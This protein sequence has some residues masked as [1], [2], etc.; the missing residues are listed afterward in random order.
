M[1]YIFITADACRAAIADSCRVDYV[2][3][4]LEINGK[5]ERQGHLNTLISRH[6][7]EDVKKVKTVLSC[8]KLLVRVNPIHKDSAAEIASVID[9][10]AD[11]I[12]LPMFRTEAEV[13]R[14]V[15]LI[16]GRVEVV[17]LVETAASLIRLKSI[18]EIGGVDSIHV[19]LNDLH[20]E[21]RL[22][23]MFEIVSDG[24]MDWVASMCQMRGVKF[25]FGGVG[26]IGRGAVPAEL[27]LAEHMR[28]GSQRVILSRDYQDCFV[29]SGLDFCGEFEKTISYVADISRVTPVGA[30][31]LHENFRSAVKH[32]VSLRQDCD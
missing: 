1:E 20:I 23:F 7:L 25:G 26:R 12:M 15:E 4:D 16:N 9:G 3:V 11:A 18:L 30:Q 5:V 19:G 2:M 27:I 17:L 28:L 21:C 22:D 29:S 8:S 13:R 31:R 6:T 32:V 14:F 10:G 24:I